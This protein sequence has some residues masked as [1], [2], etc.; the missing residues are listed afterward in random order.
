MGDSDSSDGKTIPGGPI[1]AT[2]G[3]SGTST[4][5]Q[6]TRSGRVRSATEMFFLAIRCLRVRLT[7]LKSED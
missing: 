6:P 1:P 2:G 5:I 4:P 3:L 7:F